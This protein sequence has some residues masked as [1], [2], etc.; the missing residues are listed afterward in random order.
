MAEG[1]ASPTSTKSTLGNQ[2]TRASAP[3]FGFGTST[4]EQQGK[5][6]LDEDHSKLSPPA[7]PTPAPVAYNLHAAVGVQRETKRRGAPQWQFSTSERFSN[8]KYT[9]AV[10]G[11]GAYAAPSAMGAQVQ[12]NMQTQPKFGFGSA[13]RHNCKDIYVSEEH[14]KTARFGRDTP[15]PASLTLKSAVG[16]QADSKKANQPSWVF[17]SQ[18]RFRSVHGVVPAGIGPGSYSTSA[19]VGS[20]PLSTK[21]NGPCFGFG[22][23]D[24]EGMAKVF[25]TREHEKVNAGKVSPGPVSYTHQEA[26]GR[27]FTSKNPQAPG[28]KFGSAD[29][30]VYQGSSKM[31]NPGPGAYVV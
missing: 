25:L 22:T 9:V 2:V 5:I 19:A 12:G 14:S 17:G 7:Y 11:P 16:K 27:Q 13:E 20:Q 15:G 24:R 10:P 31:S 30:W 28:W 6:F 3:S 23:S 1:F 21:A 26:I 8:S 4:R 29:R 18:Q